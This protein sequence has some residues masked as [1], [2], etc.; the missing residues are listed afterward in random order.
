MANSPGGWR[1][2]M[3]SFGTLCAK[4]LSVLVLHV[5]VAGPASMLLFD[6]WRLVISWLC[7]CRGSRGIHDR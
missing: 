5:A 2:E 4:S 3:D 1:S 7:V 6:G